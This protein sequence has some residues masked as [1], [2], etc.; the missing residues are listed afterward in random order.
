MLISI[1]QIFQIGT[2]DETLLAGGQDG[3]LDVLAG[4]YLLHRL[5]EVVDEFRRE[6]IDRTVRQI[7]NDQCNAI[8]IDAEIQS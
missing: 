2:G 4:K 7:D 3:A 5:A 8:G 1:H 6:N